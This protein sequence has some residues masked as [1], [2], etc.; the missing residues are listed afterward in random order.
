MYLAFQTKHPGNDAGL[1]E[2]VYSLG[3][4]HTHTLDNTN[5]FCA[6]PSRRTSRSWRVFVSSGLDGYCS[7][8]RCWDGAEEDD[9]QMLMGSRLGGTE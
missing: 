9:V 1:A 2:H 4:A 7:E 5:T 3:V 8:D 6:I